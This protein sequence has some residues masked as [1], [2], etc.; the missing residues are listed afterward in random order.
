[1]TIGSHEYS[2]P[3]WHAILQCRPVCL[4][5]VCAFA[6]D[7]YGCNGMT[8]TDQKKKFNIRGCSP[9]RGEICLCTHVP[10][11]QCTHTVY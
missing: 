9:K 5:S 11:I 8:R 6:A 4:V 2:L 7:S 1:M 10:E 3:C